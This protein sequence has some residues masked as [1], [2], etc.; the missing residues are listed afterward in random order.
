[1]IHLLSH[2]CPACNLSLPKRGPDH[3]TDRGPIMVCEAVRWELLCDTCARH[4]AALSVSETDA[5]V[6]LWRKY[7]DI[8]FDAAGAPWRFGRCD[9]ASDIIACDRCNADLAPERR[10]CGECHLAIIDD[11]IEGRWSWYHG[12]CA[13]SDVLAT[14]RRE[15]AEQAAMDMGKDG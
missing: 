11:G 12:E 6:A 3:H 14:G 15:D 1:M 7:G 8:R 2:P 13:P 10:E 5:R 9:E 4:T